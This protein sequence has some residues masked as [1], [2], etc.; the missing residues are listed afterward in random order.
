M[1]LSNSI[2]GGIVP[3]IGSS[4]LA[5][6]NATTYGAVIPSMIVQIYQSS[7]TM[8]ALFGNAKTHTGGVSGIIQPVQGKPMT[9]PQW[10]GVS[11]NFSAPAGLQG[12]ED[13]EWNP[14]LMICP[15]GVLGTELLVQQ[16]AA[17]VRLTD[18]RCNDAMLAKRKMFTDALFTNYTDT[19]ALTGYQAAIDDG[20]QV[21]TY[22]G[23]SR[24][25]RPWWKST[26]VAAG[27]VA[28]TRA[29]VMQYLIGVFTASG[30]EWPD[31]ATLGPKTWMKLAQDYLALESYK[32]TPGSAFAD[33][34][35]SRPRA[36]FMALD[37]AGVPVYMD[38]NCP[39]G[40]M[41]I[42]NNDYLNLYVTE[43]MCFSFSGFESLLPSYQFAYVGAV[44]TAAELVCTKPNA[45]GKVTGFTSVS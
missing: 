7:P 10:S 38:I 17:V 34:E 28:P 18:A 5:E 22:A 44:M 20:T 2:G 31:S 36:G 16:D 19:T 14:K 6:L 43:G 27:S 24:S 30:G 12:I 3:S 1:P 39:E 9:V 45:Q 25:T 42:N 33:G 26:L 29:L 32:I 11:G 15:I 35:A 40:T 8:A 4:A 13:A 21:D 41:W 23:L 37:V